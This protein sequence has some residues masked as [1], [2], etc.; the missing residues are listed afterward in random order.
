[1][2]SDSN[3]FRVP[4]LKGSINW[5]FWALRMEAYII[6]KGYESALYP[7][8]PYD[9]E[10]GTKEEY[11][12]YLAEREAKSIKA[13]ALI[14][15]ALDD[16]P[17]IQVKGL[18]GAIDIWDR[19]K[20]LYE[21]KGFSSEFLVCKEL[22]STSLATSGGSIEN[23]LT[24]IKRLSDELAARKLA[25]PNKVII[26]YA[27]NNLSSEYENT[28][29]IITQNL[30]SSDKEV[31]LSSIFSYLLDE[32]RRLKS[33]HPQEMAMNT[34]A[35]ATRPKCTFCHKRGH[36][37]NKCWEKN[38]SLRP[39][40]RTNNPQRVDSPREAKEAK[41][42]P[43]L[44]SHVREEGQL[45][46]TEFA[47]LTK[48]ELKDQNLWVL[49]SGA[50]RHICSTKALF[51]DLRPYQTTLNWGNISNIPVK[52]Q[53]N[54]RVRFRSTGR[55]ATI[56]DC[57]YVPELGLNLLSLGA[58]A[59]K[60][61]SISIGNDSI[62]LSIKDAMIAKG[63]YRKNLIA[64]DT[65]PTTEY[66]YATVDS[67]IWHQRMGHIGSTALEALPR[68]TI[69]CEMPRESS[70]STKECEICIQSKATAKI[71]RTPMPRAQEILEK[72]HSDICGP[73][74]PETFLK[75]R[76]FVSFIDDKTRY[77]TIRLLSSRDQVFD[78]FKDYLSEEENQLG[79][80][81]KRLHS[82]N[83]R[84]YKSEQFLA[85]LKDKG[86]IATYSAP[87]I[88]QQNG[89]SEIYNRTLINKVRAMLI[90]TGLPK[91][92][93]GEAAIAATY[94]YNRTPHSSLDGFITPYEAKYGRK[95]TISD[96][97]IWG[98]IAY[99]REPKET[100]KKLDPRASPYI[101]VGYGSN[102]YRLTRPS[103]R[104]TTTIA[105]DVDILEGVF[106]K[107][108]PERLASKLAKVQ[109]QIDTIANEE[110]VNEGQPVQTDDQPVQTD[111]ESVETDDQL[112]NLPIDQLDQ[113]QTE[114]QLAENSSNAV[115]KAIGEDLRP[116]EDRSFTEQLE[117]YANQD[118][119][120]LIATETDPTY[121]EAMKSLQ[122]P[123]W[124]IACQKE[125]DSLKDKDTWTLVPRSDDL[126]VLDGKW[127]LK[128]KDPYRN[129]IYKARWVARGF[130]QQSG[131]DYN[132]TF[133]NT[134]NPIAWK[135]ILAI[136]AD[137]DLEIAQWDVKGAFPNAILH[138]KVYINQPIGWEDPTKPDYICLL[139]KAL[140][141]LK[142]S[143][144]EWEQ[145]LKGLL[146]QLGLF[147]LKV[148]QSIYL[149]NDLSI[150]LIAYIDDIIVIS[151]EKPKIRALFKDLSR[152]IELKDLGDIDEFLGIK[153]TR[154]RPKRT[155]SLS[156]SHYIDKILNQYK[157][158]DKKEI[159][160]TSPIP[161]G[162]KF[163]PIE[164]N[165]KLEDIKEF[166]QQIGTL[167]YLMAKTRPD[168]AYP[169][170]YLARYMSNPSPTHFKV[171]KGI[172]EYL[173]I[174]KY[175]G[176]VYH[177]KST[178]IDCYV[179]SD[180]GGDI[181]TRRSTTGYLF[182]YRGTPLSWNSKLQRTVALSSCE[183]EYMAL[184][185]AIKE[186]QYIKALLSEIKGLLGP[187]LTIECLN[188]YTDSNSAIEL[189][190]NPVYH[191]RTKHIDIQYHYVRECVQNEISRLKWIPT[192]AQ[193]ADGLTK[194]IT[195][196]KWIAFIQ[197]IGLKRT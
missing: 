79:V 182:V 94:L 185:E 42:E 151:S 15:L 120:A 8:I 72:V 67:D 173:S 180:W 192:D 38:P 22:F 168:L 6:D 97:R 128:I 165:A 196:E 93:W 179:D 34:K 176:L 49:D 98:S 147:P 121:L 55:T 50:S 26:A 27:L 149:N 145:H 29:A 122:A 158:R 25:I 75:Q 195:T 105:R 144:R 169:V 102:Q 114:G 33:I 84:E 135:L 48:D 71:S 14:R 60:G 68:H 74:T 178:S 91:G 65:Y 103:A 11:Q 18:K 62:H 189:A 111:D 188:V 140:Y 45:V 171:L 117:Y 115:N 142:Q 166:Q 16:G 116:I 37:I 161:I 63:Y 104:Y 80:R 139:N 7:L 19:L 24:R 110:L 66:A 54:V 184:K 83:A 156:Q 85:L 89:I 119:I 138:E 40:N 95:P 175:L 186:Q 36:S 86:V 130:Q 143:G 194:P 99:K 41:N 1:M 160:L 109:E 51:S 133:A 187:N 100:L 123:Q 126:K 82:D 153:I 43:T 17:L 3:P 174:T 9:E 69:G 152:S 191:A 170:G 193:L 20:S 23:Y 44:L 39:P 46:E 164:G 4:R 57:L 61:V 59:K 101:L 131:I 64:I 154:N 96:I 136:A 76:Y 78:E 87:Y 106:I 107:D 12:L 28:V 90:S 21:P 129:P 137:L 73:M 127:V 162:L 30:R 32:T 172:R 148:D 155:I 108:T 124:K 53:G 157:P 5:E 183:A 125:I 58:L 197:G 35:S 146:C 52:W 70:I 167:I 112:V 134:V 92:L 190:K 13:S 141:G 77:A 181:G 163:E 81:L 31:D 88:P 2:S 150:V 118:V 132:E 159:K 10:K 113:G 56:Q 47:L 177:S